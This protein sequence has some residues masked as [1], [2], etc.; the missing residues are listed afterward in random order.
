MPATEDTIVIRIPRGTERIEIERLRK[1]ARQTE[2][3]L[4]HQ[5]SFPATQRQGQP[6][7]QN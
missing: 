6:L 2:L 1:L 5:V 7:P 4:M 3:E